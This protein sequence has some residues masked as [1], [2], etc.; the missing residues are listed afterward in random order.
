MKTLVLTVALILFA[1]CISSQVARYDTSKQY[2]PSTS[3]EIFPDLSKIP[4]EYEI[5]GEIRV[6]GGSIRSYDDFIA[7]L[8]TD[9]M[10][11]G[12]DGLIAIDALTRY[13]NLPS[14]RAQMIRFVRPNGNL[15]KRQL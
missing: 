14:I 9:A 11:S 5:I 12:A 6:H 15:V 13:Y 4:Y 2:P 8:K 1:G 3:V 10:K 7:K